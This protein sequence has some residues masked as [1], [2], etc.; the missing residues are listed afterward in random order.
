[1]TQSTTGNTSGN[2]EAKPYWFEIDMVEGPEEVRLIQQIICSARTSV[3]SP[4]K[5][6]GEVAETVGDKLE[7][8]GF[9]V[10]RVDG[11]IEFPDTDGVEHA[12]LYVRLPGAIDHDAPFL[13]VDPTVDQFLPKCGTESERLATT[14]CGVSSQ[15]VSW[16]WSDLT[17]YYS[18][19]PEEI[20]EHY[21]T[22]EY[23]HVP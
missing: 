2:D 10:V 16:P 6:C 5:M 17:Q 8:R 18:V 13:L 12:W 21:P 19:S 14:E 9:D 15:F 11:A 3:Q 22:R 1:M 4:I 20:S 23:V 7:Q